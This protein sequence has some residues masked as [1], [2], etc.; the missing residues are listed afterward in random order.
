VEVE[1]L[2]GGGQLIHREGGEHRRQD[3]LGSG[4]FAQ[5]LEK[6]DSALSR[7][8]Q[9]QQ[10]KFW[11]CPVTIGEPALA[12]Y[13]VE[14]FNSIGEAQYFL[15]RANT[16]EGAHSQ[17]G[18]RKIVFNQQDL[19]LVPF[20]QGRSRRSESRDFLHSRLCAAKLPQQE[21]VRVRSFPVLLRASGADA[22]TGVKIHAQQN[23]FAGVGGGLQARGHLAQV[24]GCDARVG[25]AGGQ[26]HGG[27]G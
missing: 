9:I 12:K 21:R 17:F 4:V 20:V 26:E 25:D 11:K 19:D 15:G 8:F 7:H 23:G 13:E 16:A 10:N 6:L 2:D 5:S 24:E 14:R 22:V 27:T 18:I 1:V 3:A